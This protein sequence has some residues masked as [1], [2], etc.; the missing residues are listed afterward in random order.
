MQRA[1]AGRSGRRPAALPPRGPRRAGR[2]FTW[3]RHREQGEQGGHRHGGPEGPRGAGVAPAEPPRRDLPGGRRAAGRRRPLRL[4]GTI[5][6]AQS[7]SSYLAEAKQALDDEAARHGLHLRHATT[8]RGDPKNLEALEIKGRVLADGR[9]DYRGLEEAIRVQTQIL[10]LD[11]DADGGAEAADRA[12]PEGR[13]A[14]RA[15]QAAAE[16]YLKRGADDA[17]AHRLMARALEGVGYLGDVAALDG[18]P[19]PDDGQADIAPQRHRRVREGRGAPAG[20]RRRRLPARRALPVPGK[21]PARA[22]EVMDKML[23]ANPKSV[24]ARLAR[25]RFFL[26]HPELAGKSAEAAEGRGRR[27]SPCPSTSSPRP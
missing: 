6:A 3:S 7:L 1:V 19:D 22:V 14:T 21:E 27:R 8:S 4:E 9:R 11:P 25:L 12:Q 17:E 23:E 18:D 16:E 26:R 20:R 5:A 15:A 13:P 2:L 24:P 10:A